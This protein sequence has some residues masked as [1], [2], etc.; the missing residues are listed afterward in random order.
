MLA[1]ILGVSEDQLREQST[2]LVRAVH[3]AVLSDPHNQGKTPGRQNTLDTL[4]AASIELGM[5]PTYG[6]T[7][8]TTGSST[9]SADGLFALTERPVA[10]MKRPDFLEHNG[11]AYTIIVP[12]NRMAPWASSGDRL[13]LNPH[14][15]YQSGSHC[16]FRENLDS[17]ACLIGKL[18][19]IN[20]ETWN[21]SQYEFPQRIIR[22]PRKEYPIAHTVVANVYRQ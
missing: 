21:V 4:K 16:L 7:L 1:E 20:G 22:L 2:T 6:T 12:D 5:L 13:T 15:P 19:E 11:D 10:F 3:H 14:E 9:G 18:V 17:G 8:V